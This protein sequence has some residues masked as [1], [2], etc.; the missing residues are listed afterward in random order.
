MLTICA[1]MSYRLWYG[2]VEI[3]SLR[4]LGLPSNANKDCMPT[5]T[6]EHS[7]AIPK[8]GSGKF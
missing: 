4:I 8:T 2:M 6:A 3:K 7:Q 1:A 5:P